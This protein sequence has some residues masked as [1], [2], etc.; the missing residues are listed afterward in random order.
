MENV[1]K[2][3]IQEHKGNTHRFPIGVL[4]TN[5]ET[6]DK[7][8]FMTKKEKEEIVT[9]KQAFQDGCN[10]L[11]SACTTYGA[12]PASNSPAHIADAIG[13][14][15]NNRYEEGRLQG[16]ED[17]IA[18]PGAYGIDQIKEIYQNILSTEAFDDIAHVENA[19]ELW[20]E[21]SYSDSVQYQIPLTDKF[22]YGIVFDLMYHAIRGYE[23]SCSIGYEYSLTTVEGTVIA[24]DSVQSGPTGSVTNFGTVTKN[25]FIDLLQQAFTTEHDHLILTIKYNMAGQVTSSHEQISQAYIEFTNIQARYK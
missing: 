22:L 7:H 10:T 8:L 25:V 19:M 5:V 2:E 21:F 23:S 9:I 24:S 20:A 3:V 18:D 14:I 15:Y 12:T 1:I 13:L 4:A 6:D 16:H 11:V 17:V